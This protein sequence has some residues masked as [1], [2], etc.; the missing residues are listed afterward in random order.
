MKRV[1]LILAGLMCLPMVGS[2]RVWGEGD[3]KSC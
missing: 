1:T 2:S 3:S